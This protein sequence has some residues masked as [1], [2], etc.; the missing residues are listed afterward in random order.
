MAG[1]RRFQVMLMGIAL[2]VANLSACTQESK[3]AKPHDAS[4][5]PGE[6][7]KGMGVSRFRWKPD[8]DETTKQLIS[9]GIRRLNIDVAA[10]DPPSSGPPVFVVQIATA[11]GTTKEIGR[12][13]IH[14]NAPFRATND[15]GSHQF[16]FSLQEFSQMFDNAECQFQ[17]VVEPSEQE[18]DDGTVELSMGWLDFETPSK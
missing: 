12:F 13:G 4:Q 18:M 17:V 10:Y 15:V 14:P 5:S 1:L 8:F 2:G 6:S 9:R 16:Q 11:E 3:P 7:R